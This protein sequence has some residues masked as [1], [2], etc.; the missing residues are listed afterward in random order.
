V[1]R[2][3]RA[4]GAGGLADGGEMTPSAAAPRSAG[5]IPGR[6]VVFLIGRTTVDLVSVSSGGAKA[7]RASPNYPGIIPK[8]GLLRTEMRAIEGHTVRVTAKTYP[9]SVVIAECTMELADAFGVDLLALKRRLVDE[10]RQVL[11][12]YRCDLDFAEEYTVCCVSGYTGDPEDLVATYSA[13]IVALLK[14]EPIPL[15]EEEINATLR[16]QLKY[17]K[18]DLALV[19]WDGAFLFDPKGDFEEN[20]ELLQIAN[21]ELLRLRTLDAE[22]DERLVKAVALLQRGSRRSFFRSKH[23]RETLREVTELRAKTILEAEAVDR[24]IKLI[25]DWYSARLYDLVAKK[26]HIETWRA[27]I[28]RALD[29]LE[30]VYTM[31]AENFS[32]SFNTTLEFVLIIGWLLLLIGYFLL[33]ILEAKKA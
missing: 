6:L 18:D 20:V 21:Q 31:A 26:L 19:D 30:D 22:L 15:D 9:P 27:N 25:G 12:G 7:L 2:L 13:E 23:V 33:F 32:V 3:D 14:D 1:V 11:A 29:T 8:V 5:V 28:T 16:F 24:D 17:A 4:R 10:C